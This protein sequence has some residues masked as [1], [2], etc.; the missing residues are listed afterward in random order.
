MVH[1]TLWV[2]EI[3]AG[4]QALVAPTELTPNIIIC[5]FCIA[6]MD[7]VDNKSCFM[8]LKS[9]QMQKIIVFSSAFF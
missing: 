8:Q 9:T 4:S 3:K 7:K 5:V 2:G 6:E 1:P